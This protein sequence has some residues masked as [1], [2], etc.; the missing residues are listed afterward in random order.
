VLD[1]VLDEQ[2]AEAATHSMTTTPVMPVLNR[3]M[4]PPD[5]KLNFRSW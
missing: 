5:P 2:A 4:V 3:F 1:G